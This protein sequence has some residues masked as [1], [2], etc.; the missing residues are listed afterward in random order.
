MTVICF[1]S[2]PEQDIKSLLRETPAFIGE[3]AYMGLSSNFTRLPQ[4]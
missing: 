3:V 4:V 2:S 1:S